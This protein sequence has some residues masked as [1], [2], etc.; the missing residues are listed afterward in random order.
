M[1]CDVED[2]YK[3]AVR[4]MGKYV[5]VGRLRRKQVLTTTQLCDEHF[6]IIVKKEIE[7]N[8]NKIWSARTSVLKEIYGEK[9]EVQ[10]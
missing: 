7:D 10:S 3:E 9:D 4:K 5:T 1:K 8:D 2:C 6:R